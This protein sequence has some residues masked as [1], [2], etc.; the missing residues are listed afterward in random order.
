MKI[1]LGNVE[2]R[3][4]SAEVKGPKI[5]FFRRPASAV[6]KNDA[7]N[8]L[9]INLGSADGYKYEFKVLSP[10]LQ[11]FKGPKLEGKARAEE[12]VHSVVNDTVKKVFIPKWTLGLIGAN[13]AA[14]ALGL[15]IPE[16]KE[17]AAS[18]P[19][20]FAFHQDWSHFLGNMIPLL[21]LGANAEKSAGGPKM[22]LS[23][24][25][26]GYAG[27]LANMAIPVKLPE[28][29][30][31]LPRA[32]I[33]ASGAIMGLAGLGMINAVREKS[34]SKLAVLGTYASLVLGIDM[35]RTIDKLAHAVGFATGLLTGGLLGA[36]QENPGQ[37][38]SQQ[39]QTQKAGLAPA[40]V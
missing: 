13:A 30:M 37:S 9:A 15:A 25:L 10:E 39:R 36:R 22:A 34:F 20:G 26:G 24:L 23:Y 7:R 16:V 32:S 4:Y 11:F 8:G 21:I 28:F 40:G 33:G 17:L 35:G 6:E 27:S 29:D 14:F 1:E 18:S 3:S 31:T 5:G 12:R 38:I 19:V 2:N